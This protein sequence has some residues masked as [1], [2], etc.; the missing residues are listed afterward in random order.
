M[1]E[2]TSHTFQA[3]V[4]QLL[5]IVINSL[6]T[7]REIFLRELVSN[8]SD[9]QEKLRHLQ[10]TEKEIHEADA[11]LEI[12]ITTDE[13]ANTITIDDHGIGMTREELVQNLGTIAH[14]G[15]KAFLASV[16]A[17]SSAAGNVIGKF[18]V[19]FYSVFM[20]A[21]KVRVY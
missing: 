7:D 4:R 3:E 16:E 2:S 18:G 12:S 20:V 13:T 5:D 14:S 19:G 17:G 15:T 10:H 11:P 9:A 8:A 6:Y 21:E 1:S